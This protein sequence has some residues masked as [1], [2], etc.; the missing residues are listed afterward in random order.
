M[1]H[2]LKT[3]EYNPK[4]RINILRDRLRHSKPMKLFGPF[5]AILTFVTILTC[6]QKAREHKLFTSKS[7]TGIKQLGPIMHKGKPFFPIGA[8][9]QPRPESGKGF[10][11]FSELSKEGWNTVI[12]H[13]S[14]NTKKDIEFLTSAE[15][16]GFAVILSMHNLV[17]AQKRD[18][19]RKK[20]SALKDHPAVLGYYIFDEPE[21][22]F[23]AS[24][25]YKKSLHLGSV[26]LAGFITKKLGWVKPLIRQLDPNPEHYIFMCIGWWNMYQKLNPLCNI[27]MP[28][29]YPT[30]KTTAEF[31]GPQANIVHDADLAAK[32]TYK[33]GGKGFC[34][35]PFAV[36][37]GLEKD[38]RYPTVNEFRY[39]CFAP[40][41]QGAMGIIY[42]A[43]YRCKS[44][45]TNQVVFPV[46]R[47]LSHLKPFFLGKWLNDT[48]RC[49]PSQPSTQLLKKYKIPT[50]SGCMRQSED[51]R[52]LLLAVNNTANQVHATF[53]LDVEQLPNSGKEFISGR[54]VLIDADTIRDEMRPYGV[55]AYIIQPTREP[56]D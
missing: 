31:E 45:Y 39:S 55:C 51:G 16:E 30:R 40:I 27:N 3:N 8:Y 38:Y 34:Y 9:S 14:D 47:E 2:F 41:T 24:E 7:A 10:V 18:E 56:P 50:V 5:L 52:Y 35:T 54:T 29:E 48:I 25:E 12:Q 37:I 21:N 13:V 6:S 1:V 23:S 22:V 20:I 42:W 43:G 49:E 46:T 26:G 33:T 15:A 4:L 17:A 53:Q 44:P 28:N 11:G 19:V 32:A 36:N